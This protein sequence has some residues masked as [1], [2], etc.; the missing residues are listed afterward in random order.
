MDWSDV[1]PYLITSG[2]SDGLVVNHDVR[3]RISAINIL[4]GHEGQLTNVRHFNR[5][6][7]VT[8]SHEDSAMAVWD[9]FLTNPKCESTELES[10]IRSL[11]CF[12]DKMV[13]C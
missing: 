4:E 2:S 6:Q 11:D 9:S 3:Q 1:T 12:G 7:L 5:N 10:P 8:T 13:T